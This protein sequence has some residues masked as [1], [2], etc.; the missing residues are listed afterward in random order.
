MISSFMPSVWAASS[1]FLLKRGFPGLAAFI[2][3]QNVVAWGRTSLSSSN[4]LEIEAIWKTPVIVPPG[5]AK[6]CAHPMLTGSAAAHETI[7]TFGAASWVGGS[8]CSGAVC[9]YNHRTQRNQ[10]NREGGEAVRTPIGK[11]VQY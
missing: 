9:Y 5:L 7:G 11:A 8:N 6:V 4:L 10:L 3:K 1:V 2:K